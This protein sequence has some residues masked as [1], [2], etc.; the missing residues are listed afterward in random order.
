CNLIK[1]ES[2]SCAH[3]SDIHEEDSVKTGARRKRDFPNIHSASSVSAERHECV[4][5]CSHLRRRR[6][7]APC[8]TSGC[9]LSPA[10][11]LDVEPRL[12]WV[13]LL[14][15]QTPPACPLPP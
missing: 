6:R 4:C 10:L 1:S 8:R 14:T 3:R 15:H 11:D 5:G 13:S 7:N 12:F 9:N 2:S